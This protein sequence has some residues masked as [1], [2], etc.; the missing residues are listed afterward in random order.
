MKLSIFS[1]NT[2]LKIKKKTPS[3]T[4]QPQPFSPMLFEKKIITLVLLLKVTPASA[5]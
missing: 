5:Y 4:V 1:D 3:T 2:I